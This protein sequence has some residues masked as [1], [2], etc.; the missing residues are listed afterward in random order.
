VKRDFLGIYEIQSLSY[1]IYP[2]FEFRG[3]DVGQGGALFPQAYYPS[4]SIATI[5]PVCQSACRMVIFYSGEDEDDG[6]P[7]MDCKTTLFD[8]VLRYIC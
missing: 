2:Q 1:S 3:Q 5:L 6:G 7:W 8:H 4:S